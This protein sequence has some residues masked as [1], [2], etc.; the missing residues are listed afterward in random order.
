MTQNYPR[1]DFSI[2]GITQNNLKNIDF[3]G[4]TGEIILVSGVSGSGKSTLVND[5]VAAEAKRQEAMR[6]KTD[7]LYI[8]SV[9]PSFSHSTE[10]PECM[11]V[12]QRTLTQTEF[13]TFGTRTRLKNAIQKLFVE[14]GQI[15]YRGVRIE[16][17]SLT[18]IREFSKKFYAEAKLY[19]VLWAYEQIKASD[20][21][22]RLSKHGIRSV[23]LRDEKKENFREVV[24]TKLPKTNLSSYEVS[25]ALDACPDDEVALNLASEGIMLL[26]NNVDLNFENYYFYLP[27]GTVFRKPTSLLFSKSRASSLSG[28]CKVCNGSGKRMTV[29]FDKE[30]IRDI[31]LKNGFLNVPLTKSGRYVAFKFL[32][33]G[34]AALLKKQGIDITK[35]FDELQ[36]D[37]H[38]TIIDL[39]TQ[40]LQSNKIDEHT[41]KYLTETTC[42][43]CEGTGY[44]DQTRAVLV[45][46]KS[47]DYYFSLTANELHM[48]LPRFALDD[49]TLTR[50]H[51]QLDIIER[52]AI[53]HIALNRSTASISSGEAQRLKLLEVLTSHDSGKIIIIDEPSSNLQYHD[54]LAI[55]DA[56]LDL[57]HLNNC[58]I[59]VEHNFLYRSIADRILE[60][61]PGAGA[62]GGYIIE[63]YQ[64]TSIQKRS[65]FILTTNQLKAKNTLSFKTLPLTPKRNV[66]ITSIEIPFQKITAV[67]GSSGSGKSTLVLDMIYNALS[68]L[69]KPIVKLD[70]KPPGKSSASIVGTYIE[71]LDRIRK[72]YAKVAEPYLSESDFSFNASGACQACGGSGIEEEKVCGVCFGSRYRSEVSLARTEGIGI[73]DLLKCNINNIDMSGVF[74]FLSE[75]RRIFEALSLTH[76]TLGR[77]TSSLSG[78]E[79]QRLKLAKFI[80]KNR[81]MVE[82]KHSTVILDEPSRGL[83]NIAVCRLYEAL[84]EYLKECSVIVIEHNPTL[85]YQSDYIIDMGRAIGEKTQDSIVVGCLGEKEFPSL[86]HATVFNEL[87][88]LKQRR[89]QVS[90]AP[91]IHH[92]SEVTVTEGKRFRFLH[93]LYVQQKNFDLER[94]FA[95]KFD[96]K[97]KDKNF[98]F[99]NSREDMQEVLSTANNFLYNPF[100]SYLQKYRKI[101]DTIYKTII[102]ECRGKDIYLNDD[103]WKILVKATTFDEA[104]LKGAG[105]VATHQGTYSGTENCI[106]YGI[107]LFSIEEGLVD[108]IFPAKFAFN[109]YRNACPYCHGYG[110]LKSYPLD[111]WIDKRVSPLHK[112]MSFL[113]LNR[114]IPKATISHFKKEKVFDFTLAPI[115]LTQDEYNIFLYGFKAYKFKKLGKAGAVEDDFWEWRGLNSYIYQ[116]TSKLSPNEDLNVYLEWRKCPFCTLGFKNTATRYYRDGKTIV[117]YLKNSNNS[118]N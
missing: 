19:S 112:D 75:V 115:D 24:V 13:S 8:Y 99:I 45:N 96:I 2:S 20:V 111:K 70:S 42:P 3:S 58:I 77:A 106:Y 91:F 17:P 97:V 10:L 72:A 7:D 105:V 39:L 63:M 52:L 90:P 68:T 5:V 1:F 4:H 102:S 87:E 88:E 18:Q 110:H 85:I 66:C 37:A 83:D 49:A 32:P 93:P 15:I 51:R 23:F 62:E 28:C 50:L 116:N 107:R 12:S 48:E 54:N 25:V 65:D 109:L 71:V 61:G 78:G 46:G 56:I 94:F 36:K 57:K 27:D 101:P 114:V 47:I 41:T 113:G 67:V 104:F 98:N 44:S 73:V 80:L 34:L 22:S 35:T 40:K 14:K 92:Q 69:N 74:G 82:S 30:I 9:R 31:P 76:I 16:K 86:N 100:V 21:Q 6:L 38:K 118:N 108:G 64:P 59:I 53:G 11:S 84:R 26:G 33:S 55:L 60:V 89:A 81:K 43:S 79:L 95:S 29:S 103:P 117:S